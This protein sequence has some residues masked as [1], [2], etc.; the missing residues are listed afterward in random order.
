M[1]RNGLVKRKLSRSDRALLESARRALPGTPAPAIWTRKSS[2]PFK[3]KYAGFC[4]RCG[5]VVEI[6]HMIQCHKDFDGVVHIG[7][8][9]PEV[10][11]R[12]AETVAAP[13]S[14][15]ADAVAAR[16]P[17]LCTSCNLEHAG[18]CW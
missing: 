8:R 6:G 18:E 4:G 5:L 2:G 10:V 15:G 13:Q 1:T 3:A 16:Q 12:A 14:R 9:A 7:C 11:I 17:S